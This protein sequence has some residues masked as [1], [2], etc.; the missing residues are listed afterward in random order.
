MESKF[1][2]THVFTQLDP[3]EPFSGVKQPLNSVESTLYQLDDPPTFTFALEISGPC[4]KKRIDE[5]LDLLRSKHF[6]LN[7]SVQSDGDGLPYLFGSTHKVVFE[8][9]F[10]EEYDRTSAKTFLE[11][12]TQEK[13]DLLRPP[14]V[15]VYVFPHPSGSWT[16]GFRVCHLISDGMGAWILM[17]SFLDFYNK[18]LKDEEVLIE[19]LP[20]ICPEM[21]G[22]DGAVFS[23]RNNQTQQEDSSQSFSIRSERKVFSSSTTKRLIDYAKSNGIGIYALITAILS[24]EFHAFCSRQGYS[25]KENRVSIRTARDTRNQDNM[26]HLQLRN[27]VSPIVYPVELGSNS[28]INISESIQS[29]LAGNSSV[30]SS[31]ADLPYLISSGFGDL[32]RRGIVESW[33]MLSINDVAMF[34]NMKALSQNYYTYIFSYSFNSKLIFDALFSDRCFEASEFPQF[35]ASVDEVIQGVI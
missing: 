16:I 5:A 30:H 26:S 18:R 3:G 33:E 29:S 13:I 23:H 20:I 31:R 6:E 12:R 32:S 17:R 19:P 11:E 14:L 22:Y 8:S 7:A 34:A 4:I 35:L 24:R 28:L 15:S 21:K 10:L 9:Q 1:R 2:N 27:W 25:G